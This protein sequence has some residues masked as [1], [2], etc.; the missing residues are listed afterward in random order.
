[1]ALRDMI[2]LSLHFVFQFSLESFLK[3]VMIGEGPLIA[4]RFL[5]IPFT[6][7]IGNR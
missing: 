4:L 5:S 2:I 1:M 7:H 3:F 6:I